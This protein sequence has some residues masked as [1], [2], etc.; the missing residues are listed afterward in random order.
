MELQLNAKRCELI[1][2]SS[3]SAEPAFRD[4]VIMTPDILGAPLTEGP[5]LNDALYARCVELSRAVGRL[6][7]LPA[8][9]A[10]TLLKS[11]FSA[12]KIMYTLRCSPSFGNKALEQ[13]DNLLR[14][15]LCT[16]TNLA[17]SDPQWIQASLPVSAGGLGIRRVVSLALPAFLASAAST[18]SL[19][20]LLLLNCHCR[21]TIASHRERLM[22]TW[23]IIYN[24]NTP[25][26]PGDTSR[27]FG[28]D[29]G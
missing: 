23:T 29:Q 13:F 25:S 8:H 20:S 10:L 24:T 6:S 7:L 4:F 22:R 26:S 28:T 3:T 17:I 12:P 1:Q 9:D 18:H 21:L 15:G 27:A 16:I 19:Q 11:S 5:S 14:S 2:H